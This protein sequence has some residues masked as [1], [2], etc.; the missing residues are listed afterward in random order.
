MLHYKQDYTVW[1][2]QV[3]SYPWYSRTCLRK[4]D[5]RPSSPPPRHHHQVP[6]SAPQPRRPIQLPARAVVS[7]IHKG[8][9][10]PVQVPA[11]DPEDPPQERRVSQRATLPTNA[12]SA[13][14]TVLYPLHIQA[15]WGTSAADPSSGRGNDNTVL[16]PD[17]AYPQMSLRSA[18]A[19]STT[20][21]P[22]GGPLPLWNWP[23][24]DIMTLPP[25][26]RK[27]AM[28]LP[29]VSEPVSTTIDP[30]RQSAWG[31]G[32]GGPVRSP[33]ALASASQV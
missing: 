19:P 21:P 9:H 3:R 30:P 31:R 5:S 15:V 4:L 23:R 25:P 2:S 28:T 32:R 18:P 20:V 29:L 1:S 27:K 14:L 10:V 17:A 24:A 8:E 33:P 13:H 22:D 12:A 16:S 26:S 6:I 11:Q 7:F